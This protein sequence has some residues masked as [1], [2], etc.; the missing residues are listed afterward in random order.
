[1]KVGE[2]EVEAAEKVKEETS[3]A[4]RS[5]LKECV[6]ILPALPSRQPA[7]GYASLDLSDGGSTSL[8]VFCTPSN[9]DDHCQGCPSSS[10]RID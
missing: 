5:I 7:Q 8:Q 1:M 3:L 9:G 10:E 6:I 2:E 4:M